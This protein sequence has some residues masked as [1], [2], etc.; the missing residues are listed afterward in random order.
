VRRSAHRRPTGRNGLCGCQG[1]EPFSVTPPLFSAAKA[2]RDDPEFPTGG[3]LRESA[4]PQRSPGS[5][6]STSP[7]TRLQEGLRRD[8]GREKSEIPFSRCDRA[9]AGPLRGGQP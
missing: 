9:V 6:S 3:L 2:A 8:G 4:L 1:I 5:S 7:A